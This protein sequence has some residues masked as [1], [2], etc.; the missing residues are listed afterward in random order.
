MSTIQILP[1]LVIDQIAAGEV[2]EDPSS[3]VRELID[4]SLDAKAKN[5]S[6]MVTLTDDLKITIK[7]DG[8][9]IASDDIGRAFE[10]HATSKIQKFSDLQSILTMGFRGEA[11]AAIASVAL[12]EATSAVD[13]SAM[14]KTISV[15]AG[16][17]KF[18]KDI[19][20]TKGTSIN[21]SQIFHNVPV[22]KKF[23]K[24]FLLRDN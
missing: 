21:V 15:Q 17:V 2:V 22:R 20:S 8:V 3:I 24:N 7:D 13:E 12:V 19:H 1:S 23:L 18:I 6:V 10:R 11:L 4:N 16:E 9:G 5:I 14:G